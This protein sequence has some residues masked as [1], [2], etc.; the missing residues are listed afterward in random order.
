M[1]LI[2]GRLFSFL[3]I[4]LLFSG[5]LYSASSFEIKVSLT[6]KETHLSKHQLSE[7]PSNLLE[8]IEEDED[9][10]ELNQSNCLANF[11]YFYS[12]K[13]TVLFDSNKSNNKNTYFFN[14]ITTSI[15]RWLLVRHILL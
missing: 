4:V 8:D 7:N 1:K 13:T 9:E 12:E 10:E 5:I 14:N 2:C 6:K 15:P 3:T 11:S